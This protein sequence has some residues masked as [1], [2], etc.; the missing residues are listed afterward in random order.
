[1]Y[2]IMI[3]YNA[4]H[5]LWKA[6]GTESKSESGTTFTE[7]QTEDKEELKK[8]ILKLDAKVGSENIIVYKDVTATYSVEITEDEE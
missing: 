4:D 1:M 5:N 8:E 6:Y 3:K 2:K 7:F